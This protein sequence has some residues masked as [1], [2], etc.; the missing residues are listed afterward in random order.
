MNRWAI[1]GI[2]AAVAVVLIGLAIVDSWSPAA[3]AA[4]AAWVTAVIASAAGVIALHQVGE[5]RRLRLEQAQ[6]Y[7]AVFM[8]SMAEVDPRFVDLV[9]RNFGTTAAMNVRIEISPT[10]QRATGGNVEDVWIP[11]SIPVLVPA[12]EWSTLW[13]FAPQRAG[14]ALTDRHDA[15]VKFEDTQGRPFRFE[16]V[17]DWAV[18]RQRMHVGTYGTHHA[19][20][21]LREIDQKLGRWQ[22]GVH[23]G[24]SVTVRDGDAKDAHRP[25]GSS[26]PRKPQAP[27]PEGGDRERS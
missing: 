12:Q 15:I 19:A 6:P 17:L 2:G 4:L 11:D 1:S 9:I 14:A 25:A 27:E 10:P 16:Y 23:G 7:V 24:L 13:D 26:T 3:W 5:A 8:V 18:R 20:E 21:A 22:E